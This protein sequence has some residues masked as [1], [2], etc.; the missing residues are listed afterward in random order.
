M[1]VTA[2]VSHL[3]CGDARVTLS[4]T[5]EAECI[6]PPRVFAVAEEAKKSCRLCGAELPLSEFWRSP[7]NAG[8]FSTSCK[9]CSKMQH[10]S[11][12]E[13]NKDKVRALARKHYERT[14][15]EKRNKYARSVQA[16]CRERL[17]DSYVK[18]AIVQG[19]SLRYSDVTP[20]MVELKR[21]QLLINRLARKLKEAHESSKDPR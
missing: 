6:K 12:V 13:R 10:A 7:R 8:G 16:L 20:E 19:S 18:K 17:S 5:P 2:A 4:T 21:Q 15:S 9:P 11:W 1:A 3:D 14:P